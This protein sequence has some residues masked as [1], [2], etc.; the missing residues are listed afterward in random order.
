MQLPIDVKAVIDEAMDIEGARTTPL[1]VSRLH[2]RLG[3]RRP[4]RARAQRVRERERPHA[5]DHRLSGRASHGPVPGRRHGGPGGRAVRAHRRACG[6]LRAAG[7]PSWWRPRCPAW[8][9]ASPR[10]P[11]PPF[12]TE[13]WWRRRLRTDGCSAAGAMLRPWPSA[14]RPT[15]RAT[16]R[17]PRCSTS[18]RRAAR[19][20]HGGVDH[21]CL[22]RQAPRVRLGVPLRAPAAVGRRRE[23][24]RRAERGR[25][26]GGVHPGRRPA[27]HDPQPGEDAAP[28]RGRLRRAVGQGAREGAGGRRGRR[29]RLPQ[30][31][32]PDRWPSCRRWAGPSRRPSDMRALLPWAARPSSTSRTAATCPAS[33][34]S[35]PPRATRWWTL[36]RP[37][38]RA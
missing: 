37:R 5:R 32:A 28:D 7:V 2:R 35:C 6:R 19:P 11:A 34:A 31:G 8:W 4:D 15:L 23:R 9:R 29:V 10:R 18:G 30:R 13:T 14:R 33:W 38:A 16:L 27:H 20:P 12:L 24:H 26:P 25:G 1:S 21:R 36:Q 3:A 22:P 17:N